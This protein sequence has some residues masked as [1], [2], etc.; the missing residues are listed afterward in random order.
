MT[1]LSQLTNAAINRRVAEAMGWWV[2]KWAIATRTRR[3]FHV[4]V[5]GKLWET[6]DAGGQLATRPFSPATRIEDAWEMERT[7]P[8]D[9]MDYVDALIVVCGGKAVFNPDLNDAPPPP[10]PDYTTEGTTIQVHPRALVSAKP[11]QR[12]EAFL[13]WRESQNG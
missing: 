6:D 4:A 12:C 10:S 3:A 5:D 8:W 1:D 13:Q 11:R 7:V 2:A 9:D